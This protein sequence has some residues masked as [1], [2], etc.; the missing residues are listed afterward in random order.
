MQGLSDLFL[1]ISFFLPQVCETGFLFFLP[2]CWIIIDI[3]GD[4]KERFLVSDDSVV[5][6]SLPDGFCGD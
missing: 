5:V 4:I 3:V 2:V 1:I 6:A